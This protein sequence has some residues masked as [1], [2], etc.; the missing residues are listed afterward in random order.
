MAP[1]KEQQSQPSKALQTEKTEVPKPPAMA[2]A[3]EPQAAPVKNRQAEKTDTRIAPAKPPAV[4]LVAKTGPGQTPRRP[5]AA[6][7]QVSPAQVKKIL[8]AG[9][10][11]FMVGDYVSAYRMWRPLAEDGNKEAQYNL[12]FMYESGWGVTQ[13]FS[14]ALSWYRSA[15]EQ[16]EFRAQFNLG[17]LYLS[18]KG[19]DKNAEQGIYWI[20]RAAGKGHLRAQEFL[21]NAYESGKYGLGVD[22]KKSR[23]WANKAGL[24]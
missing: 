18:G 5:S 3:K 16:G 13:N 4:A 15:A 2:P 24:E 9:Q 10:T 8:R 20:E 14:E 21:A 12:G 6:S 7:R 23:F 1:V 17:L 22:A 11:S 19:V